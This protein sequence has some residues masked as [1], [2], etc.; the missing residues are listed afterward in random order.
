ME[1]VWCIKN[2][3]HLNPKNRQPKLYDAP[4]SIYKLML[5]SPPLIGFMDEKN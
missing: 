1:Y 2:S 5:R 4:Y 3:P